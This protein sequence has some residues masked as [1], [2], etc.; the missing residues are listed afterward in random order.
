MHIEEIQ[1]VVEEELM[2]AG[3][4]KVAKAYG[5]LPASATGRSPHRIP[6]VPAPLPLASA[7][8]PANPASTFP[9]LIFRTF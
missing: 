9:S 3:H 8:D 1:D 6:R 7:T 5:M 4:F 2:K